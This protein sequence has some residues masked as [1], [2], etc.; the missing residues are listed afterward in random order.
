LGNFATEP[1]M[2]HADKVLA[3]AAAATA[4]WRNAK[5]EESLF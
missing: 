2:D 3:F 1:K 4:I 5:I